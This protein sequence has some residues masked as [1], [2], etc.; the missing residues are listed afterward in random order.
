MLVGEERK[1]GRDGEGGGEGSP[2]GD[3]GDGD[4]QGQVDETKFLGI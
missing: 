4:G 1:A 2:G 3:D